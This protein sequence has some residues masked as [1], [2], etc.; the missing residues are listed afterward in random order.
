V[1]GG[2]Q[3]GV[4]VLFYGRGNMAA[5][6]HLES[7]KLACDISFRSLNVSLAPA[8]ESSVVPV[9]L[10][11]RFAMIKDSDHRG[12]GRISLYC[13]LRPM[14]YQP[15]EIGKL[16]RIDPLVLLVLR[17]CLCNILFGVGE[18]WLSHKAAS[19]QTRSFMPS[20]NL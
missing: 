16:P 9:L 5:F 7:G 1:L 4:M 8:V 10:I 20:C 11:Q 13:T 3:F 14:H 15:I 12:D 17:Q 18:Q 6:V 19:R 2:G